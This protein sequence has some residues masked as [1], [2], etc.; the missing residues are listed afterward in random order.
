MRF[1]VDPP[2][3]VGSA[4]DLYQIQAPAS[5]APFNALGPR[6]QPPK[7]PLRRE[8]TQ[9]EASEDTRTREDRRQKDRRQ[10]VQAVLVDTRLGR[11]RRHARRRPTDPPPPSI[12]EKA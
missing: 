8:S 3:P 10:Y 12:D 9:R 2:A 7:E 11:D 4:D 6:P 5:I 1:P